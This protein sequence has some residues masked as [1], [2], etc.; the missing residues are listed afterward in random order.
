[1]YK[2]IFSIGV[3]L[4]VV[5]SSCSNSNNADTILFNGKIVTVDE[6]FTIAQAVAIRGDR[7]EA[8]GSD[9]EIRRLS[10]PNTLKIDLQGKTVLP[11]LIDAHLHPLSAAVSELTE[12]IPDVHSRRELLEYIKKQA[13]EKEK[14]EWII[15]PRLFPTRLREML[16]P[17][18]DELDLVAPDHPVFLNGGYGGMVNSCALRNSG[19]DRQTKDPGILKDPET[20]EPN[21]I[22]RFS[23]FKLIEKTMPDQTI[24]YEQ[25]LDALEKMIGRYNQVGITGITDGTEETQAGV[26]KY[27]DLKSRNRLSVRVNVT[28]R[29]PAY[30]SRVQFMDELIRWGFYSP[31]GDEW[32]KISQLKSSI[33]G[34]ILTGTAFLRQPW[35]LKAKEI[36]GIDDP[37]YRGIVKVR[38]DEIYGIASAA[39]EM[40]WKMT[41]HVTGG[42]GVDLLLDAYESADQTSPIAENRFSIIHGNFFT[43]EAIARC[44]RMGVISDMQPAWFYK[45]ADAMH[46]ILGE[47]RIK[48]FLPA[49]SMIDGGV[50]LNGG[51][52][53]MVKF[54][55][56]SSTNPYNPF[57]GMW[58]LITRTTER[59]TVICADEAISREEALKTYT[60]NNAYGTFDE[61]IKGSVEAG[62]LADMIVISTDYLTCP[63]DSIRTIQVEKTI[64]GGSVIYSK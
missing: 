62:K 64:L 2:Q 16:Q 42:G 13:E 32:V 14:G 19:I 49:R 59:G 58:V 40:G 30:E 48:T 33:D 1:M 63:V 45:D 7:I 54:D 27:L 43:K 50:M 6:N 15:H 5:L 38:K 39:N 56:Y 26:R 17:S 36:Y 51:S 18:K 22:I 41:A 3:I 37:E 46:Y 55:S 60:I 25:E 23:A 61:K 4:A 11:G 53:H 9:A 34:G 24:S 20:G 52:D 29:V 21:G 47:E 44:A 35:G 10:G 57:L 12:E 28:V 31:F 8:T